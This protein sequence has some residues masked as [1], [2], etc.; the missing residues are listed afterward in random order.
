MCGCVTEKKRK[1]LNENQTMKEGSD[2]KWYN[3]CI[4][5]N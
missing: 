5:F 4:H 2:I 1:G 3:M